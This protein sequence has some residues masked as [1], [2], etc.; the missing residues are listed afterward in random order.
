MYNKSG[1]E[2]MIMQFWKSSVIQLVVTYVTAHL[3]KTKRS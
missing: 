1:I 2:V 3:Q